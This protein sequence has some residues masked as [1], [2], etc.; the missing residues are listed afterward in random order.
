MLARAGIMESETVDLDEW[1]LRLFTG[2]DGGSPVM[3]R[4]AD[5]DFA[6][7]LG[8]LFY[9]DSFGDAALAQLYEDF[10]GAPTLESGRLL[11][12]YVAIIRKQGRLHLFTDGLGS[13]KIY[14]TAG[15]TVLSNSFI[16]AL[17]LAPKLTI[18]PQ[19]CYEYAWQ[20]SVFGKHTVFDE[21]T[22]L[23]C[24][25]LIVADN[26]VRLERIGPRISLDPARND[27][28]LEAVAERCLEP[29]RRNFRTYAAHFP[30]HIRTALSGGFDS[31]LLLA[32]LL[33]AGVSP[34]LYV[35]GRTQD[36]DV[37]VARDIASGMGLSLDIIDKSE[38]GVPET[39]PEMRQ[40]VERD[41]AGFDGWKN[42]GIFDGGVDYEDRVERVRDGFCLMNGSLGEIFRNFFYLSRRPFSLRETVWAFYWRVDPAACTDE[43]APSA[44]TAA[45]AD[46]SARSLNTSAAWLSRSQVELLYPLI[47]GR[48]W[49]GR[50]V[51]LNQRFGPALFPFMEPSVIEGTAGIPIR[52]KQYGRL[53]AQMIHMI[54]PELAAYP[55]VYGYSLDSVEPPF[56]YKLKMFGSIARPP[57][58]RRYSYRLQ[59]RKPR[60]VPESVRRAVY[61]GLPGGGFSYM[62]RYFRMERIHD[63]DVFTRVATMELLCQRW[64]AIR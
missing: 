33:D 47:R 61:A 63:P 3:V 7:A 48:Y 40:I 12:H 49:T 1:S 43:F 17:A 46:T 15:D 18:N 59:Y 2:V 50:D 39:E 35:Y 58:L 19:A 10:A 26:R 32:L 44:Y 27:E 13:C 24:D 22:A 56:L 60:P 37:L 25:G 20:G 16:A 64:S 55:S 57:W 52:H 62:P 29:L 36:P 4:R 21:V 42:V 38:R 34:S 11:G 54:N 6:C 51:A 28:P 31:R 8:T 23:P 9:R 5:G 30:H 41:V 53:E 45:L 14:S